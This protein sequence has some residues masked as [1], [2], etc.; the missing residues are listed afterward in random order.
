[1][2]VSIKGG[3]PIA[4]WFIREHPNPKRI[5]TGGTPISGNPQMV[6]MVTNG[7]TPTEMV[8]SGKSQ[9]KMDDN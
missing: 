1:M 4:G 3:T 2:G 6:L 9:S 7:G 8:Y 5:G